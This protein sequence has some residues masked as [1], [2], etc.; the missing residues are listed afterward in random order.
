[1]RQ[2]DAVARVNVATRERSLE[3]I[4]PTSVVSSTEP[5]TECVLNTR[6]HA[7]EIK[8]ASAKVNVWIAKNSCCATM[9]TL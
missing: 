7:A 1:M 4:K 9:N 3:V 5:S 8:L 6:S 2:R